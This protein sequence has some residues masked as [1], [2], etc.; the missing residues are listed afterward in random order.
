M[1]SC[2]SWFRRVC[3][4]RKYHSV[5]ATQ[6]A[7]RIHIGIPRAE[8]IPSAYTIKFWIRQLE[9]TGSTLSGLGHG[10]PRTVRTPENVQLVRESIEQ[11]PRRTQAVT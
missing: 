4:L 9:E 7:F 5:I 3:V 10:A 2:T 11:S 8:S 1:D 6:R